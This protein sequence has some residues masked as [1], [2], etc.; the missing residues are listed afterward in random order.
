L[1]LRRPALAAAFVLAAGAAAQSPPPSPEPPRFAAQVEVITVDVLVLDKKGHPVAGLTREDFELREDGT[2]QE[3][4]TF[5]AVQVAD[6]AQGGGPA[7]PR[8][9]SLVVV[10]DDLHLSPL[11]ATLSKQAVASFL[12]TGAQDGDVV[13]LVSTAKGTGARGRMP[14]AQPPLARFLEGLNG[15]LPSDRAPE[16]ISEREAQRLHLHKDP[17]VMARVK[18]RFQALGVGLPAM[19]GRGGTAGVLDPLEMEIL[20]R[21]GEVYDTA[22]HRNISTLGVLQRCLDSLSASVGRKSVVLVSEGFEFDSTLD[23]FREVVQASFRANAAVY[24]LDARG[25]QGTST[26]QGVEFSAAI[27]PQDL[28]AAAFEAMDAADGAEN[29]ALDSGGLVVRNRNDL[30]AGFRE[31]AEEAR[32]YYLLGYTPKNDRADGKFRKI[33]VRLARKGLKVRARKG[34]FAPQARPR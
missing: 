10:V 16:R 5:D 20:S 17:E 24:F 13:T 27:D 32:T 12:R 28:S 34:Y 25:L 2:R 23:G 31:I 29:M 21:A 3:I 22:R 11:T 7:G 18:R 30:T 6:P 14:E 8:G 9:R 26:Y 19:G 1:S 15:R 33:D 4:A